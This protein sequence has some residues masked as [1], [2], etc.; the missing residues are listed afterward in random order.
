MNSNKNK[1]KI[2]SNIDQNNIIKD[3]Y[4]SNFENI[5]CSLKYI[6]DEIIMECI[7]GFF[8]RI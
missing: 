3:G 6:S 4:H 8:N 7:F 1:R 5:I 2:N